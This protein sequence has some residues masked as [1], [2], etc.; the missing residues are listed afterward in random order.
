M[1]KKYEVSLETKEWQEI[2]DKIFNKKRK[3][4]KVDGFRKGQISKDMYIKKFGIESLFM[5]AVDE[6]IPALYDK[7]MN[8]PETIKPICRPG[9]DIKSVSKDSLTVEFLLVSMPEVKLGKY[10]NLSIK[11]EKPSVSKE[12]IEHEL[13]HLLDEYSDYKEIKNSPIKNGH[14]A[15]IDFEGFIDDVPFEGGKALNHNLI[16]G[17][18]SF[19][20]GFEDQLI[21]LNVNEEK[22]VVVTFPDDYQAPELKGKQAVFKVK[23]N[24]IKEKILPELNEEF[25]KDLGKDIHSKEELEKEIEE[26]ILNGKQRRVDDEYITACLT[27][28]SQDS[29]YEIP[30]EMEEDEIDR[31]IEEFEHQISHQGIK[32]DN[33][34][35]MTGTTM[36]T[37][38]DST[39]DEARKRIGYRIVMDAVSRKED[40]EVTEK[41]IEDYI[42]KSIKKYDISKEDLLNEI[43]GEDVIIY[44]IR[45][46]KAL[47]LVTGI[48][49]EDN[50]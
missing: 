37:L 48:K 3:T 12:E 32:L 45:M 11:K 41:E 35:S 34:F 39:K 27:K 15:V 36:D 42:N 19:I 29:K 40:F 7:L 16:I 30:K 24:A 14:T 25:F 1:R 33:Y 28:V 23:V 49:E 38:R 13:S 17:S 10:K 20:P 5:D 47:E 46:K 4:L 44:D 9:V 21:G 50:N 2:L 18:K 8:D 6:A 43:G 22:D 31:I 26:S